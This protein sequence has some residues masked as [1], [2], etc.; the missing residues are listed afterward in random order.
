MIQ[1]Q[2]ISVVMLTNADL[3]FEICECHTDQS[4]LLC[5]AKRS[6]TGRGE[7]NQ[8]ETKDSMSAEMHDL[9]PVHAVLFWCRSTVHWNSI[10]AGDQAWCHW[11][12]IKILLVPRTAM[13]QC[14]YCASSCIAF[15]LHASLGLTAP[16]PGRDT[17]RNKQRLRYEC[18]WVKD[19]KKAG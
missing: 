4:R 17:M 3:K 1:T 9:L 15:Q 12:D 6:Q 16:G 18:Q 10:Y 19:P 8:E 13:G 11:L 7:C 2:F 5:N 14:L